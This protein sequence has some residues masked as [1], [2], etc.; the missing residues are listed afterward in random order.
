MTTIDDHLPE[1]DP[2][3]PVV[4]PRRA[5]TILG[6]LTQ[7]VREQNWFAVALE[8]V[9]VVF[10]VVI[11]FQVTTW[12]DER[13]ARIEEQAL[14]Q[15]LQAEFEEVAS[16]LDFMLGLHN[17][18]EASV[19]TTLDSLARARDSGDS[20]ATV[21]DTM[22]AWLFVPPTT[23]FSQG[24]LTGAITT[25]RL[26]LIQDRELQTA[27]ASWDGVLAEMTE[28]EVGSRTL[29]RTDVDPVFRSRMDVTPFRNNIH[30][31]YRGV[32]PPAELEATS[33]IP[34]DIEM[35]GVLTARLQQQQFTISEFARPQAEVQRILDL[36][37]RSL[38]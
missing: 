19:S 35:L 3:P 18:V 31:V 26:G 8:L 2:E 13:A 6:R 22:L 25:G 11:G 10:G 30:F 37:D 23:Q 32:R 20:F 4:R 15:G 16:G 36:I 34:V 17:R 14:L 7:A 24:V 1:P 21:S 5:H 38:H 9:I 29:V 12:G 33:E 27:L 28:D